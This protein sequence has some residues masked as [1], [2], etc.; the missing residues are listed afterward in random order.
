MLVERPNADKPRCAKTAVPLSLSGIRLQ[1]H[2]WFGDPQRVSLLSFRLVLIHTSIINQP[3][4]SKAGLPRSS[5]GAAERL[6]RLIQLVQT[7][8]HR[9]LA[10]KDVKRKQE[11][12]MRSG[13]SAKHESIT[14]SAS[15]ALGMH[16]CWPATRRRFK[17]KSCIMQLQD[18]DQ[19][20]I[21]GL[22]QSLNETFN[23]Q[24]CPVPKMA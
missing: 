9:S 22:N 15:I 21:S 2:F 16:V 14:N 7:C 11:L 1:L 5:P 10:S 8:W 17:L 23:I 20:V 18:F 13:S 4:H 6:R 19:S 3:I 24:C 12:R